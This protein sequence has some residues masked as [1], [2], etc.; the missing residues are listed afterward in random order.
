LAHHPGNVF[1][2]KALKLSKFHRFLHLSFLLSL[3]LVLVAQSILH[4]HA[5][6]QK[7]LLAETYNS[8]L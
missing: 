5:I 1:R 2:G 6:V 7:P 4:R 8:D 3:L